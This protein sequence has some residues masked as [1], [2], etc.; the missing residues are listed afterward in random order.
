MYIDSPMQEDE[1]DCSTSSND[2]DK[3]KFLVTYQT[4]AENDE[5]DVGSDDSM[6]SD[7]S[8]GPTHHHNVRSH[9]DYSQDAS[10]RKHDKKQY[11]THNNKNKKEKKISEKSTRRKWNVLTGYICKLPWTNHV[12]KV[13]IWTC[14]IMCIFFLVSILLE[15]IEDIVEPSFVKTST[16]I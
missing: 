7:A 2:N 11:S 1:A 13:H 8:S 14:C 16:V 3:K 4:D 9:K 5:D 6:A 10:R 15:W 12:Q